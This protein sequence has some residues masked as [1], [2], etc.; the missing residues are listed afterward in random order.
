MKSFLASL[1]NFRKK[2]LSNRVR[3]Y[4]IEMRPSFWHSSPCSYNWNLPGNL[5]NENWSF[6]SP[7]LSYFLLLFTL[8]IFISSLCIMQS[9]CVE[10]WNS[11]LNSISMKFIYEE[12]KKKSISRSRSRGGFQKKKL[13]HIQISQFINKVKK[14]RDFIFI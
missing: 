14:F 2:F 3:S 1:L 9:C 13:S 8:L 11:C 12:N 10:R 7:H 4:H 5:Q 6:I